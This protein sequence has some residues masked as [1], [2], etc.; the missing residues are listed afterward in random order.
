MLYELVNTLVKNFVYFLVVNPLVII[1]NN[2]SIILLYL[3]KNVNIEDVVMDFFIKQVQ[4][5]DLT[6][7][8]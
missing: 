4:E 5:R 2:K 8:R 7:M 6:K 3:I 1:F